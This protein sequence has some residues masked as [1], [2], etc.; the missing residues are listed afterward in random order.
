[1]GVL[2]VGGMFLNFILEARCSYLAGVDLLKYIQELGG[3]QR[4]WAIWGRKEMGFIP[5]SYQT[6][7]AIGWAK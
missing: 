6:N 2:D 5:S 4:H 3:N 7:Q 1:M